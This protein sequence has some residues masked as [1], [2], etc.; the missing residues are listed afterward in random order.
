[1]E[2]IHI[3]GNNVMKNGSCREAYSPYDEGEE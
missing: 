2:A 3:K 1:M